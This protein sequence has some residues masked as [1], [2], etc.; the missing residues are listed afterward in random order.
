MLNLHNNNPLPAMAQHNELGKWGEQLAVDALTAEGFAI[1]ERNWRM[2]H[3]EIDIIAMRGDTLVVGEVK[4]RSNLDEDP[5]DAVDNKKIMRMVRAANAY[6]RS[7]NLP[8]NVRFDLFAIRG[9]EDNYKFEHV[10]DAF[11]PPLKSYR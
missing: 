9:T 2:G 5:L 4:T 8:H 11:Y 3:L 10:P 7:H 6:I 1:T